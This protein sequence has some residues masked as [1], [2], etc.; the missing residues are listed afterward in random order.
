MKLGS[1]KKRL[2]CGF[3]TIALLMAIAALWFPSS[4]QRGVNLGGEWVE[5]P[6]SVT[7]IGLGV[8]KPLQLTWESSPNGF[9]LGFSALRV[10]P[11]FLSATL[12]IAAVIVARRTYQVWKATNGAT[13][14]I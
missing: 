8:M 14:T 3:A 4:W 7:H 6:A 13:G 1:N 10:A 11:L 2:A 12:T 9:W 5:A